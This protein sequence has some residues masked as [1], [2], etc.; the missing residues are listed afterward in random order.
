M[1]YLLDTHILLWALSGSDKLPE[2]AV[3][4]ILNPKNTIYY[5]I[6]S[7]WEISIKHWKG[8]I[9]ISGTEFLHFCEIAGY[10]RLSIED[11]DICTLETLADIENIEHKD[12]FD[13][14]LLS[15]AKSSGMILLTRDRK[16]T[17]YN[18]PWVKFLA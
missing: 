18:E 9:G 7:L 15:Q 13:R 5:S 2:E 11:R 8:K 16:L 12:P 1:N 10:K 6:A 14:I 4:I 17:A 3:Q